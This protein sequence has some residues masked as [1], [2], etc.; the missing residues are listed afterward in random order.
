MVFYRALL[1]GGSLA[2]VDAL[3]AA[4]QGRGPRPAARLRHQP[5]RQAPAAELIGTLMRAVEP[6]PSCS[7]PRASPSHAPARRSK[8]P[9]AAAGVPVLQAIFAGA[10][11][12]QWAERDTRPLA[13]RH[14][15]ERGAARGGRANSHPRGRV[16]D[17][18][19]LR[20]GHAGAHRGLGGQRGALPPEPGEYRQADP[21]ASDKTAPSKT[22]PT[23]S[24]AETAPRPAAETSP[25]EHESAA[26]PPADTNTGAGAA[27]K[28]A[29]TPAAEPP[30]KTTPTRQA[31]IQGRGKKR[32]NAPK[33][34][35]TQVREIRRA[36]RPGGKTRALAK[37]YGVSA[38]NILIIAQR[39]TW[40]HLEP[41][42]GEYIPPTTDTG[43]PTTAPAKAP[44]PPRTHATAPTR[45]TRGEGGADRGAGAQ[46][47]RPQHPAV[48]AGR[49]HRRKDPHRE[50]AP[51]P[52]QHPQHPRTRRRRRPAAP[53]RPRLR[54]QRGDRP[55]AG[56]LARPATGNLGR[57]TPRRP[58]GSR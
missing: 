25:K 31:G 1:Q 30:K 40:Q 8:R 12:R 19:P 29:R 50:A 35:E 2:P 33:L 10:T 4:L 38:A 44:P 39:G 36:Y 52:G 3:V 28:P 55:R 41:G 16:Q 56:G 11:E 22:P 18:G 15:H 21:A 46:R 6:M 27:T 45:H 9:F 49:P 14:R 32:T 47:R 54:H 26:S 7:T 20:R 53:H 23:A 17:R 34:T 57:G 58:E 43:K 42:P 37:K 5:E 51:Q 48:R 13:P 24:R